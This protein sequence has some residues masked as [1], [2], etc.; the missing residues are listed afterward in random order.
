MLDQVV[1]YA[2]LGLFSAAW[3]LVGGWTVRAILRSVSRFKPVRRSRRAASSRP[4][5]SLPA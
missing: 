5:A 4:L 2:G 3:L 1:H